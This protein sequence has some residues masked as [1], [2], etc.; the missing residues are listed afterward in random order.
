MVVRPPARIALISALAQ[1]PA[2]A[3]AAMNEVW[4]QARAFNL[5]DDSLAGDLAAMGRI[6]ASIVE[7]FLTLGRY[8]ASAQDGQNATEGILFTC[9]AFR[10]AIDRVKQELS[11]PVISPN[12]AA[13]EEALDVTASAPD[14]GRVGLLLTFGGS[15]APLTAEL[16]A[17]ADS[18]NQRMP[19]LIAA[20]ADGAL[21]ALQRG[22][23]SEHDRL[24]AEAALSMPSV[25]VL[26]LGQFSM[27]RAAPAVAGR[28]RGRLLTTPHAAVRKLRRLV[29][30]RRSV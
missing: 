30:A 19:A 11:I 28:R 15:V 5:L 23:T 21:D 1:S 4:P 25:D 7:R 22:E 18:R 12:E 20:V 13:F 24:I 17:I 2:P 16:S 8:A 6:G 14:G 3:M 26:L 27:S 9:S 10:P 29:E